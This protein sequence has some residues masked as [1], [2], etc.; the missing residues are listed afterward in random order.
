MQTNIFEQNPVKIVC[1]D[2][3]RNVNLHTYVML[4]NISK[5]IWNA[6]NYYHTVNAGQRSAYD[7]LLKEFYGSDFKSKLGLDIKDYSTAWLTVPEKLEIIGTNEKYISG[8]EETKS[9]PVKN[10]ELKEWT[11]TYDEPSE[12]IGVDDKIPLHR[13]GSAIEDEIDDSDIEALLAET[14]DVKEVSTPGRAAKLITSSVSMEDLRTDFEPGI[15]YITDTHVYP[16]DKFS[17][18]K[19]KIYLV[20]NIPT[21]RQHLF[22]I[23]R[24]RLQTLYKIHAEGIYKIDI[25]TLGDNKDNIFGIP[26]DKYLYDIRDSIRVEAL[27]T[28][29]ILGKSLSGDNVIYVVDLARFTHRIQSQLVDMVNDTYQFELFYYGFV[30]KYWPQLTQECFYDYVISEP[31]LQ[32]KYPDLAKNK[33]TLAGI[34]KAEKDIIDYNYKNITRAMSYAD[35]SGVSIA[36]TQMIATVSGNRVMLNIRNLFDKLRVTRCIPEIHAYIE[37]NN[38]KYLLRKR[39]IRNGSDIQFPSGVLMKNG[40]TIA[41]S[42]RKSDQESFHAKSTISIMENEQSRYL[43][44]NIWPNGKYYVRTIWNEED[45]LDFEDIIKI[46]KKFTDPI[47]HGINNLGRYA[48]IAGKEL[49]V[50]TKQNISYQSL[51]ICI[52]WKKVML[53]STFK[54]I[55]SLWE[56]YMR[57]RITGQRNVQ[58]F[59]KY[60]FLF[61]KGMYEFDTTAIERIITA[62]NNIILSNYYSYLSNNTIKQKWEQNYDGRIVKMSHRTTDVRFEVSD[63]REN[64]FQLF[65]QYIILFVYRALNDEKVKTALSSTRSYKDVKKLRKLREQDPELFNLKKYGSKKVYSIICQN[66]RQPLIYT[67]DE[68]KS[69]PAHEVKKLVQY[70]NFTLNKPAFYG[71]PNRKYPHLSFMVGMHPKHYCL[72]CCNKKPQ[73][74]EGSKKT[75]I[76]SIC[77][78]KHKYIGDD[79]GEETVIS[80]HIMNYGKDIDIGRLSKLPQTSIKNLLF[81]TLNDNKLNYYLYGVPQHIPGIENIGIIYAIAEAMDVPMEDLMKR[82]IHELKKSG[83]DSIFNTLLNGTLSEYF[84]SLDDLIAS[85]KELFL[86]MKMFSKEFQRFKQWPELFTELFHILFKI[87]LFTFIDKDGSGSNIELFI[88]DILKNEMLYVSRISAADNTDRSDPSA[89]GT[90]LISSL[91]AEQIY[92]MMI[93]K[94]NKYYPIFVI[95]ADVYFK[96]AGIETRRF[97]FDD[98]VV[99]LVFSMVKYETRE[100]K[101]SIEKRLD[102]SV[103]KEFTINR[104]EYKLIKKFINKQNLCYAVLLETASGQIYV[105]IEYSVY[106]SD[107]ID[108]SF[109]SFNRADYNLNL[110]LLINFINDFNK[111]VQENYSINSD[112]SGLYS[113]KLLEPKGYIGIGSQTANAPITSGIVGLYTDVD[114]IFYFNKYADESVDQKLPVKIIKYDYC[115]INKLILERSKPV[116]DNRTKLIG[117][118]L[119]NN[120]LYQL[121]VIEFVNF[122]D[123]ERNSQLRSKIKSLITETNFKKDISGFRK[124]IRALLKDYP[125]DYNILQNQLLAFY[126]EHFNKE[127]LIRQ[128]DLT[129]YEFDRVTMNRLKKLPR[130]ELKVELRKLA[131]QFSVQKDFDSTGVK[132]P[133]IYMPCEDM[134]DETGYCDKKKLIINRPIDDFIDIL[135]TDLM[136]DLKSKYLMNA[137]YMDNI[138]SYLEFT[139]WQT[140]I[141]TIYI[142]NE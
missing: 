31:E 137:I 103:V 57:A 102:L 8:G 62:S 131:E 46:M 136:D 9:D 83:S 84:R 71:C 37:Y 121:F 85:I 130:E 80:R 76:N 93:K 55:R 56:P 52:F 135:A 19:D 94:Q 117:E 42:L 2:P 14:T 87:S 21:Y 112:S 113:Y 11:V 67:Q 65:Q 66:Q 61:R 23:D 48:F 141:V 128:I 78:Q 26:I 127:E 75:R 118:S 36:I 72:P 126:Y 81:G 24:N 29:K 53:E 133:N 124:E 106:I 139:V 86:D 82:L 68:L 101:L 25:R 58:Q 40:I 140:E 122:L 132:F 129:T 63:I 95:D 92:I 111:F 116:E 77:L 110:E 3:I 90:S 38:K 69:M 47:I 33:I 125:A 10:F 115:E 22:Y 108:V 54:V 28:F 5:G 35:N 1:L 43:F 97:G 13:H 12:Y 39:H 79:S 44:L 6:C 32:H 50:I 20:S 120:Y 41:I 30:V 7:K 138:R 60:E 107:S 18:L 134:T 15:E 34:Y 98:K 142:L 17:E 89:K 104:V 45:E 51:N 70:W 105:P 91:M 73:L 114:M 27:D 59:D 96:T 109:E 4:G 88:P 99:Q 119:Y 74:G 16:E 64:E 49:P 100:D 123:N